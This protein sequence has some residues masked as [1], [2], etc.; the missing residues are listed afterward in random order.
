MEGVLY[1]VVSHGVIDGDGDYAVEEGRPPVQG[2]HGLAMMPDDEPG[3]VYWLETVE[4]VE[5]R[6][7]VSRLQMEVDSLLSGLVRKT[8]MAY[9]D[10]GEDVPVNIASDLVRAACAAGYIHALR[11]EPRGALALRAGYNENGVAPR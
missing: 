9:E 7:R 8:L 6:E 11:E 4:A 2:E 5:T 10:Q 3:R 1:E